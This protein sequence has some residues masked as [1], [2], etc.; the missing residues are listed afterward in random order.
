MPPPIVPKAPPHRLNDPLAPR[1][2]RIGVEPQPRKGR[3]KGE[4]H[5]EKGSH[6]YCWCVPAYVMA[7]DQRIRNTAALCFGAITDAHLHDSVHR[8]RSSDHGSNFGC[9]NVLPLACKH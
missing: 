5:V 7:V 1:F 4:T 8:E 2:A 6:T 3:R 9:N